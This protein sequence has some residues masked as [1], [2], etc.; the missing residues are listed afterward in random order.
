MAEEGRRPDR[1]DV[2]MVRKEREEI[3]LL[4][5]RA[6]LLTLIVQMC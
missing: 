4:D 2:L 1:K 6:K 5:K 3:K